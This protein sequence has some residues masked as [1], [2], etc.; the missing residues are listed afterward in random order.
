MQRYR[1]YEYRL[2]LRHDNADRRL[3]PLAR[4][5][6]LVD[7][8]RW[9]RLQKKEEVIGA[10]TDCLR[11]TRHEQQTLEQWLRRPE[12]TWEQV[13]AL[14]PALAERVASS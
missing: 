13:C 4:R 8:A 10:L 11:K 12:T 5:A 3:T 7:D 1:C 6:G 2:V 9:Q 14:S